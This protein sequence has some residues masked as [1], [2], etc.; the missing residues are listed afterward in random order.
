MSITW[1]K[2]D[3]ESISMISDPITGGSLEKGCFIAIYEKALQTLDGSD[4]SSF[5]DFYFH[6][7]PINNSILEFVDVDAQE[8][9]RDLAIELELIPDVKD[10]QRG[11]SQQDIDKRI[12]LQ[13]K[14]E[15]D[16]RSRRIQKYYKEIKPKK[17]KNKNIAMKVQSTVDNLM[18]KIA[19]EGDLVRKEKLEEK[20]RR[21]TSMLAMCSFHSV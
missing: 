19:S 15:D 1:E 17:D 5:V 7:S 11:E 9:F 20:L 8:D 12:K 21:A 16:E 18:K 14:K 13:Y 3:K 2:F 10:I 4:M 6:K